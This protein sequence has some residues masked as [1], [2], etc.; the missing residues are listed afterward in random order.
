MITLV[1]PLMPIIYGLAVALIGGTVIYKILDTVFPDKK[2]LLTG[3]LG[4][5]KTTFLR[6]LTKE[7][8]PDGPSGA[9][10]TYKIKRAVF[11]EITDFSGDEAWLSDFDTRIEQSD[12][13]L[14]FFDVSQF[15]N[16]EKYQEDVYARVYKINEYV[17]NRDKKK[18]LIIATHVDKV[19]GNYTND[20][21]KKFANKPYKSIISNIVFVDTTKK[22]S[23]ETIGNALK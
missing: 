3:P 8:I 10:K 19:C 22:D 11:D 18:V 21:L 2:T 23:V 16:N 15:L 9:P 13:V 5:G 17:K 6:H 4:S 14:F 1:L 12:F 20:V 7:Y